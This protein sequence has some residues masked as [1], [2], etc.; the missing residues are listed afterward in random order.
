MKVDT[1]TLGL[2]DSKQLEFRCK[3][4]PPGLQDV[5]DIQTAPLTRSLRCRARCGGIPRKVSDIDCLFEDPEFTDDE[6]D[7][8]N[9]I[10]GRNPPWNPCTNM[11]SSQSSSITHR[12]AT[13]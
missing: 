1:Y 9:H 3:N 2:I 10:S 12:V 11:L 4:I 13:V 7:D 5:L 8:Y 6:Y